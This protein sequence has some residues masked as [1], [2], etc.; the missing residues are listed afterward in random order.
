MSRQIQKMLEILARIATQADAPPRAGAAAPEKVG[1]RHAP[2]CNRHR[3]TV[4]AF[5]PCC[6]RC[7]AAS[8]PR[9]AL[10]AGLG[11]RAFDLLVSCPTG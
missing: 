9:R 5:A 3:W 6:S 7:W 8:T 1:A 4:R 11:A 10:E 2:P